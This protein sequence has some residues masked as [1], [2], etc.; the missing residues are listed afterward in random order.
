M[1][2]SPAVDFFALHNIVD[3]TSPQLGGNLDGQSTYGLAGMTTAAF[4]GNVTVGN[5]VRSGVSSEIGGSAAPFAEIYGNKIYCVGS[6][7]RLGVGTTDPKTHLHVRGGYNSNG[8]AH[9]NVKFEAPDNEHMYMVYKVVTSGKQT[10]CMILEGAT[11]KWIAFDYVTDSDYLR[12]YKYTAPAAEMM[13]L[14]DNGT[15]K[16]PTVYNVEVGATN[17]ALYIDNTGKIGKQPSCSIRYKEN[18]RSLG[19]FSAIYQLRP[20]L[21]DRKDGSAKDQIGLIAEEVEAVWP[22][23]VLY[24]R[25][26]IVELQQDEL[27]DKEIEKVV[28]YRMLT[29]PSGIKYENLIVPMLVELQ[30]LK[31]EVEVLKNGRG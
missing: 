10:G 11:S 16:F 29:T 25:E 15:V 28:G 22:D 7:N 12:M 1:F 20:V 14:Y 26:P 30:R 13:A 31:A 2:I 4:S 9:G 17:H 24:E 27:C 21:F 8:E 18:V 23:M 5:L 3:D 6:G 19:D